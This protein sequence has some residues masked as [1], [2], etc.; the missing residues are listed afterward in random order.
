MAKDKARDKV[1]E[2]LAHALAN[3]VEAYAHPTPHDDKA[4]FIRAAR[5]ALASA[6][7]AKGAARMKR[8]ILITYEWHRADKTPIETGHVEA[9]EES[10]MTRIQE[11]MGSGFVSGELHDYVRMTNLDPEDG[12]EYSGYWEV[13]KG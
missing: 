10:A 1:K 2:G 13:A 7:P 12:V 9:L 5:T 11:Q 6:A 4:S 3:L 8:Q